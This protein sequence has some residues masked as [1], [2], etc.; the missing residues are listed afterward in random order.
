M[1]KLRLIHYQTKIKYLSTQRSHEVNILIGPVDVICPVAVEELH[2][3]TI[4]SK[5]QYAV[6]WNEDSQM[7]SSSGDMTPLLMREANRRGMLEEFKGR[8]ELTPDELAGLLEKILD[9]VSTDNYEVPP[10]IGEFTSTQKKS[11]DFTP[12][13]VDETK[14]ML[15]DNFPNFIIKNP[16][17]T[18][19]KP[20]GGRISGQGLDSLAETLKH[21]VQDHGMKAE[22]IVVGPGGKIVDMKD[23][24]DFIKDIMKIVHDNQDKKVPTVKELK[25]QKSMTPTITPEQQLEEDTKR[26]EEKI[27][28]QESNKGKLDELMAKGYDKKDLKELVE[29][30]G[31]EKLRSVYPDEEVTRLLTHLS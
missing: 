30:M 3:R 31:E 5:A 11:L 23:A 8:K 7:I 24:P 2:P 21:L 1:Q 4:A 6:A 25:E 13:Q 22:A 27:K 19:Q 29:K 16:N 26:E 14:K 10:F 28:L 17:S 15:E 20:E 9:V 18:A 12:E